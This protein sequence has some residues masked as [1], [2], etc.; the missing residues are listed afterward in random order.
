MERD[1]ID[2]KDSIFSQ[3]D[4]NFAQV[5]QD[6]AKIYY[7]N[8]LDALTNGKSFYLVSFPLTSFL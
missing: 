6:F 4:D 8:N 7:D 5:K 3:H 1:L 2:G